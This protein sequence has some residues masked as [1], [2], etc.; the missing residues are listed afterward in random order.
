[1]KRRAFC[2]L[3][4]LV[5]AVAASA[6]DDH[7][8]TSI[9]PPQ[10]GWLDGGTP[11]VDTPGVLTFVSGHA[12]PEARYGTPALVAAIGR[13]ARA[14]AA[15]APGSPLA[16]SDLSR[17]NG[18]TMAFHGSHTSGRDV[19]LYYF[20]EDE[21]G[22]PLPARWIALD[23]RGH[24]SDGGP[25]RLDAARTWIAIA[26]LLDDEAGVTNVFCAPH[27][28]AM[29]LEEAERA[30]ASRELRRRA[31]RILGPP[32][33]AGASPHDE[34]FHVRIACPAADVALG[35]VER[36]RGADTLAALPPGWSMV[37]VR[38]ESASVVYLDGARV[39]S[40]VERRETSIYARREGTPGLVAIAADRRA[41]T[42][43]LA[44]EIH[45]AAGAVLG[46]DT[47]W[48]RRATSPNGRH[49]RGGRPWAS[50]TPRG[51]RPWSSARR[52]AASVPIPRSIF[53]TARP[54]RTSGR[55]I[56]KR[57]S[58]TSVRGSR[59]QRPDPAEPGATQL[60]ARSDP[61]TSARAHRRSR[62]SSLPAGGAPDRSVCHGRGAA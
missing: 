39:G 27:L 29:L 57:A 46:S 52:G 48:R 45:T 15:A 34:H 25:E 13:A 10:A 53:P 2:V 38:V 36:G 31:A 17:E 3:A 22:T 1:M 19:D 28:E 50:T 55:P 8:G 40:C 20:V 18:G 42:G 6:Q 59:R 47:S 11:V 7:A 37:L 62:R 41:R 51:R 21:G 61:A 14:V 5:V 16:V 60:R 44:A 30:G 35:C 24:A 56:P 43:M 12:H 54:P 58:S 9:G 26:S 32:G 33:T 4:A 23:R 49:L